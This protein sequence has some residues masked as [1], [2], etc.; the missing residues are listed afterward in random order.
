MQLDQAQS[1]LTVATEIIKDHKINILECVLHQQWGSLH[2]MTERTA[3]ALVELN[4][5]MGR[6][7]R[8]SSM[9]QADI[10]LL[11]LLY[12]HLQMGSAERAREA[13][14]RLTSSDVTVR[15][16]LVPS[17]VAA[18][19]PLFARFGNTQLA[20]WSSGQAVTLRELDGIAET[21]AEKALRTRVGPS[22]VCDPSPA[23]DNLRTTH[24]PDDALI[25]C[26]KFLQSIEMA[27]HESTTPQIMQ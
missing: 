25:M 27:G 1:T 6:M 26:N 13:A 22:V 19:S 10:T 2:V 3:D 18:C 17:V 8:G 21:L 20:W 24:R 23:G 5:S 12:A 16:Y 15:K 14:L 7:P 11:W 4:L 9:E